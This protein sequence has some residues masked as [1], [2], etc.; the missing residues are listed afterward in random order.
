MEKIKQIGFAD[1]ENYKTH[2]ALCGKPIKNVYLLSNNKEYGL[3]CA[4]TILND[5]KKIGTKYNICHRRKTIIKGYK[6]KPSIETLKKISE[7]REIPI[8]ELKIRG[9]EIY[10]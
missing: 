3:N 10:E 9:Y 8:S 1:K 7:V 4:S 5:K 2:C 6:E